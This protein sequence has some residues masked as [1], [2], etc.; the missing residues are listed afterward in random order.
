MIVVTS[1]HDGGHGSLVS[2]WGTL[3]L[4]NDSIGERQQ[5]VVMRVL[6]AIDESRGGHAV[7]SETLSRL[8]P[9]GTSFCVVN[10]VD[11]RHWSEMPALVEDARKAGQRLVK[12]ASERLKNAGLEVSTDVRVGFP[13]KAIN[14]YAQ[15]WDADLVM[16]GSRGLNDVTRFLLGSVAQAVLRDAPCSVEIVRQARAPEQGS[17]P[18][19]RVLVATDG[20]TC[21]AMA[22]RSVAKLPWPKGTQ[23]RVVTAVQLVA[24]EALHL[25]SSLAP[26]YPTALLKEI[27]KEAEVQAGEALIEARKML[28]AAGLQVSIYQS[29]PA[30]EPR[31]VILEEAAKWDANLI[32]VGSHGRHGMDRL[33]M[34]SVSEAVAFH[35]NCSVEV[36]RSEARRVL[37][38]EGE[39]L[40]LAST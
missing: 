14:K 24:P 19:M 40:A 15:E 39:V 7:V 28:Q 4:L 21:S 38:N 3:N 20:S 32:V 25:S 27:W 30:C 36:V 22:V 6:L 9:V 1:M 5:E 26:E 11:L 35:A 18:P 10:I 33:L 29:T 12:Q 8:W 17:V 34:G 13:D 31:A 23:V 16:V 2:I 37:Q